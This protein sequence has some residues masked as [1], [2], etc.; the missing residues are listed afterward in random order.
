ME[1]GQD[2]QNRLAC[3]AG[4]LYTMVDYN[5]GHHVPKPSTSWCKQ[6]VLPLL[7]E[8]PACQSEDLVTR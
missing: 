8:L 2:R 3:L 1:C 6:T 7:K 5:K 4:Y